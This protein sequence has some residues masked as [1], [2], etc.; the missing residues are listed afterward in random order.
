VALLFGLT[1]F[2]SCGSSPQTTMVALPPPMDWTQDV[3]SVRVAK[4]RQ[5]RNDPQ[6]PLPA[7]AMKAF[8]GLQYWPPADQF[9]MVG[10]ITYYPEPEQLEIPTSAGTPRP[11]EKI[12]WLSFAVAGQVQRLQV[13][14]MLDS[15][16]TEDDP[17]FFLPFKDLTSGKE[18]YPTGR[19]IN[20]EGPLGGPYVLDFNMA[21][22]P[23]CA[24]GDT[25]RFACPITPA[26]NKLSV[27]IEAG[28]RGYMKGGEHG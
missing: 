5:F 11:A 24:Y 27:R 21:Y 15:P 10:S 13:Y 18:T 17:G 9:Y 7:A 20:L 16:Q 22:N 25:S 14:R 26:E 3:G 8:S 23:Y 6:T 1:V 12:G 28:E 2:P 19:Y 4:D